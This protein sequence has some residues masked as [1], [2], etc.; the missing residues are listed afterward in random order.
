MSFTSMF[1]PVGA[2]SFP[3]LNTP[4][5]PQQGV[6]HELSN[7]PPSNLTQNKPPTPPTNPPKNGL[8]RSRGG[9]PNSPQPSSFQASLAA[10]QSSGHFITSVRI[11]KGRFSHPHS[12]FISHQ[13]HTKPEPSQ[14][15]LI[16][17]PPLLR[18]YLV[19]LPQV[20]FPTSIPSSNSR[21]V[22]HTSI[23]IPSQNRL[24]AQKFRV[25][26][27]RVSKRPD[28]VTN[29]PTDHG[30]NYP[31]PLSES[32]QGDHEGG[33]LAID[34]SGRAVETSCSCWHWL[35]TLDLML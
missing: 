15:H 2:S 31:C 27:L 10:D 13:P 22:K 34:G 17:H 24:T 12:A 5:T 8:Y 26:V 20:S 18:A 16:N 28:F 14:I 23:H 1:A 32:P 33:R 9:L 19:R 3:Q 7:H 30:G 4:T 25:H 35:A 29:S 21:I 6:C 11:F